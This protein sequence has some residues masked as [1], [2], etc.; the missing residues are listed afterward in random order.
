MPELSII[1]PV[2][3]VE[4]YLPKCIDSILAQTFRDFELILIDDGSP[5][6]CGAICDEYA[7]KDNRIIVIHQKNAGVSAARNAGLEI[8]KGTYIGFVDSDDWI[9]PEMYAQLMLEKLTRN[10]DVVFCC[11]QKCDETGQHLEP[12]HLAE[13][14]F[15]NTDVLLASLFGKPLPT[16]GVCWNAL[17]QRST[18]NTCRFQVGLSMKEDIIFLFDVFLN[19]KNGYMLPSAYYYFR[20]Q[21]DS[22]TRRCVSAATINTLPSNEILLKKSYAYSNHLGRVATGKVLDDTVRFSRMIKQDSVPSK[23]EKQKYLRRIKRYFWKTYFVALTSGN[24]TRAQA[25]R[26]LSEYLHT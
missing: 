5:D 23:T 20:Q 10:V 8:A 21:Q 6:R 1:V 13:H 9:H 19:C 3:K 22:A 15:Q 17:F 26:Y 16:G 18:I 4:K 2:Y 14:I 24:I 11:Y 7:A 25:H 12:A